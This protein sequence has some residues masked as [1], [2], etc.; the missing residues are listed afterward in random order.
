MNPPFVPTS[1]PALGGISIG[2][3][4]SRHPVGFCPMCESDIHRIAGEGVDGIILADV[5][6]GKSQGDGM[7]LSQFAT[8][9]SCVQQ[10]TTKREH[11]NN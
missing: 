6:A 3:K 1:C 4:V 2:G 11:A 10:G 8:N 7:P 9:D 5:R